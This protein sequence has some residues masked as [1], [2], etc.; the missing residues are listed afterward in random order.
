MRKGIIL[1]STNPINH[2]TVPKYKLPDD[3]IKVSTN[4]DDSL[5]L[6]KYHR[7]HCT[8]K[9]HHHYE[10]NESNFI[11]VPFASKGRTPKRDFMEFAAPLEARTYGRYLELTRVPYG[12]ELNRVAVCDCQMAISHLHI[13]NDTCKGIDPKKPISY[14]IGAGYNPCA[15]I[16]KH[17]FDSLYEDYMI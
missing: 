10:L 6:Y 11:E 13:C 14:E 15:R 2:K 4:F 3:V 17:I 9:G 16:E 5:K 7:Y 12:R 1:G 8:P